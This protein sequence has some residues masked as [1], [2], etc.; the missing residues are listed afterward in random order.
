MGQGDHGREARVSPNGH[1]AGKAGDAEGG[2][3]QPAKVTPYGHPRKSQTISWDPAAG[4][5]GATVRKRAAGHFFPLT[6]SR[7]SQAH[8]RGS[9]PGHRLTPR[10]IA[11]LKDWSPASFCRSK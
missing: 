2:T 10:I 9:F 6:S 4:G 11:S 3:K 8:G 1:G 5:S 7:H